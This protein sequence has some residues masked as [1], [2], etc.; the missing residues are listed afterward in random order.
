MQVKHTHKKKTN[1]EMKKKSLFRLLSNAITQTQENGRCF[2]QP[3]ME[4]L[5]DF[6]L[7]SLKTQK[8]IGLVEN[9]GATEFRK[10]KELCVVRTLEELAIRK[11]DKPALSRSLN[12]LIVIVTTVF[13][14]NSSNSCQ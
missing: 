2:G 6:L 12:F 13:K 10:N 1:N 7:L 8:K 3:S 4:E 11:R 5:D 9:G 14:T